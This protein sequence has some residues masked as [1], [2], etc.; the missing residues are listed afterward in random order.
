MSFKRIDSTGDLLRFR[1]WLKIECTACRSA[2]T[3]SPVEAIQ[4]CGTG[5]LESIRARLRCQRCGKRE[6]AIVVLPPV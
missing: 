4:Q 2:R 1:A 6:A 3:L 5:T